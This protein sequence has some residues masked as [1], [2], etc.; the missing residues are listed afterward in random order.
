MTTTQKR[1]LSGANVRRGA[2]RGPL[3]DE[4]LLRSPADSGWRGEDPW[5][6]LRIQSEFV[7][8]FECL[9]DLGSAVSVFGSARTQPGAPYYEAAQTIGRL[10]VQRGVAVI[11]GGGPGI[12]AAANQGADEAD[13]KSVGLGIELPNE[14]TINDYVNLGINFRYFFTRKVM[15]L[16]YSS[17]FI[18]MPGGLGTLDELFETL[19]L[20]QTRRIVRYPIVLFGS[21]Y[22]T[23]LWEWLRGTALGHGYIDPTDPDM[24]LVTDDPEQAVAHAVSFLPAQ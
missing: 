13:G 8:G 4:E 15:F 5:R 23:G 9:E 3:L 7:E 19:T 6:V 16:K 24:V 1:Y 21:E 20:I 12:M 2:A 11:T 14:E 22:W 17:G 10:L 18:A